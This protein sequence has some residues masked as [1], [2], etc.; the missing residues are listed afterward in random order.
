MIFEVE[1]A[2][3]GSVVKV[4]GPNGEADTYTFQEC[5][6]HEIEAFAELLWAILDNYGPST[7][8]YSP[9]RIYIEV[10][11]GDKYESP[12]KKLYCAYCGKEKSE[13]E[14]GKPCECMKKGGSDA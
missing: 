11:P 3:N 1:Y 9:K 7:S 6:G 14:A 4:T 10:R 2:K 5:E 12:K 8:R 13:E